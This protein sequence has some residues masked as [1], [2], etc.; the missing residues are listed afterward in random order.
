[1]RGAK[2][3]DHLRVSLGQIKSEGTYKRE[4]VLTSVQKNVISTT[5]AT[6]V[7]NFCSNN[8]LGFCDNEML[9]E[10]TKKI[11]RERGFG[12]SSSRHQSGT[13]DYH[14]KLEKTVADFYEQEDTIIY[15][16]CFEANECFFETV[17]EAED[18]IISDKLNHASIINGIR[19]SRAQRFL[20]D[21]NNM[22]DLENQL[23]QAQNTRFKVIV[24]D[25]VFSMDGEIA[26]VGQICDLAEKYGAIVFVDECHG[27]GVLGAKG[28]GAI[29]AEN[30]VNRVDV[31]SSTF[32]KSMGGGNGGF[33]TGKKEIIDILRQRSG[34]YLGSTSLPPHLLAGY[35]LAF[36]VLQDNVSL[37]QKLKENINLFRTEMKS[38][39]FKVLGSEKAAICPVF[40]GDAKLAVD[41]ADGLL[42]EGIY[43]IGFSYPVVPKD[44][45]RIRVQL[46][47]RHSEDDVKSCIDAFTKI[48]RAKGVIA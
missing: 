42:H 5:Q 3:L 29:E 13:T 17:F 22:E 41:F 30:A 37:L 9:A 28:R 34:P 19:L 26:K 4:R 40:F 23:I 15:T 43:V 44:K 21:N 1:M 16:S 12:L 46:S 32:G 11:L 8:Y 27:T 48:G 18:A 24:T 35:D 14:L 47:A 31:V 25:G 38:R 36:N 33:I 10:V 39:G 7:L 6:N 45:A 2:F 20:Y